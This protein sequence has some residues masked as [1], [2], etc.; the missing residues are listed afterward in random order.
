MYLSVALQE[1]SRQELRKAL[2]RQGITMLREEEVLVLCDSLDPERR[3]RVHVSDV[4][5]SLTRGV[6]IAGKGSG[7][8]VSL[9]FQE[10]VVSKEH[11]QKQYF[12]LCGES[13]MDSL[14]SFH[15]LRLR[16][17]RNTYASTHMF[18]C[19]P[20]LSSERFAFGYSSIRGNFCCTGSAPCLVRSDLCPVLF[21]CFPPH[22][23]KVD[24][25]VSVI[26]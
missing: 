21:S 2:E 25:I 9:F 14:G 17:C 7:C 4:R 12:L 26:R 22:R 6:S 15:V 20:L 24:Y 23:L 3:G 18:D 13:K 5:A 1:I 8:Q 19:P 16:G 10:K 11:R